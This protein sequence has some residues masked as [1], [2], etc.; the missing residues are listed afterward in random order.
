MAP[1]DAEACHDGANAST[2]SSSRSSAGCC[3]CSTPSKEVVPS[4]EQ[5]QQQPR[6]KKPAA[7]RV[8]RQL[9]P[10]EIL[11]NEELNEA[12]KVL[13]VNYDFEVHKTVW[14]V[15]K[16]GVKKVCLQFPEGLMMYSCAIADILERFAG[17]EHT[18]ILGDTTFGACCVDDFSAKAMGCEIL[19]HYGHSCLVPVDETSIP[20]MYI[21]V[22]MKID[23][24]HFVE[25]VKLSFEPTTRIILAGTIQFNKEMHQAKKVFKEHFETVYV[26]QCK[27]LSSGEVLGCTAP[28]VSE[29][30]DVIVFIAD[31]RF[32]L[33]ALMIA[34]PTIPA[35]RYDPYGRVLTLEKYD[36]E[37][38]RRVRL[39]AIEAASKA[40]SFGLVLGTLGRQGNPKILERLERLLESR[41]LPYVICLMSELTPQK[42]AMMRDVEAWIQIA[43]P[44]LSIDW[45]E[46]FDL[47]I[48]SPY[49][50]WQA[51][52]DQE[53]DGSYRMD[54]Y[55]MDTGPWGNKFDPA[56]QAATNA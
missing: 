3:G 34:N 28:R 12:I 33:E 11:K 19:I 37:D 56:K 55:S 53:R 6:R 41:G 24:Q 9:I 7:R 47:P 21:F 5:Q 22:N 23:L 46:G 20:C 42:L 32:H 44:R 51:L 35:Y 31:G 14:R 48:L 2:C 15:R 18:V 49:E 40:K 43:C 29:E 50:A 8:V 4:T 13:N 36:H 45:G 10:D 54:F 38:M 52:T 30:G 26:P 1:T 39:A 27:P 17:V 16:G 25:S